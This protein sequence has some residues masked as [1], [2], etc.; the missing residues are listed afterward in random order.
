MF[1]DFEQN[2]L[3]TVTK[4]DMIS[5]NDKIIIGLS[6]GADS[7]ALLT[8]LC[9]IR[10]LYN[11]TLYAVHINHCIR[12]DEADRDEC[13]AFEICRQLDVEFTSFRCD[14]VNIAKERNI[15]L[16]LAGREERYRVFNEFLL[17]N[18]ADKIAV[19]H[20]K[21]DSAETIIIKQLKYQQV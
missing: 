11:L 14:V 1:N 21:N 18:N 8:F 4:Y 16:E 15:S 13:F 19:A 2:A 10:K 6:G 12:D 17:K 3:D 9:A 7:V 5:N 20:N